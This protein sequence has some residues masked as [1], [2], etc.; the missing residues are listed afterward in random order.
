MK[1]TIFILSIVLFTA[2]TAKDKR[3]GTHTA[4]GDSMVFS[5]STSGWTAHYPKSWQVLTDQEVASMEGRGEEAMEETLG[6]ELVI[7]HHNLL[8]L[9]K[10][11]FNSMTSNYQVFDPSVDGSYEENEKMTTDVLESTYAQQG[12][13]FESK[14]ENVTIDG[15]TFTMW[16]TTIFSPDRTD[17]I[18]SQ[19]MYMRLINNRIALLLNIN[20]SNPTDRDELFAIVN[21]SKFSFR[22]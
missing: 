17:T 11:N 10:D 3:E 22:D 13:Q 21:S 6:G 7:S 20:Y 2:C 15:L 4:D 14:T 12:L 18:M 9:K 5:D 1:A 8:W 16:E 19:R